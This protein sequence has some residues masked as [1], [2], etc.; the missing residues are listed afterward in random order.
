M[1]DRTLMNLALFRPPSGR[2]LLKVHCPMNCQASEFAHVQG[3]SLH[4]A[5]TSICASAI[6][7]G[8]LSPSGGDL[9][10]TAVGPAEQ[11]T[12][13]VFNGIFVCLYGKKD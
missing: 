8:V 3:S 13:A 1:V 5:S 11:Y 9:V 2:S 6:L 4:P 10:V 7:D 12:G